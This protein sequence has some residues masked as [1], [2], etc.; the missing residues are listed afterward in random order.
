MDALSP[1][2]VTEIVLLSVQLRNTPIVLL[3]YIPLKQAV[4]LLIGCCGYQ[5]VV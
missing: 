5:E 1:Y 4:M 2:G 3:T